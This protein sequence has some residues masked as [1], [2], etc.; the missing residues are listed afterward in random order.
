MTNCTE[1]QPAVADDG[2]AGEGRAGMTKK[3]Q[4]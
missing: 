1:R 3:A 2:L 4:S